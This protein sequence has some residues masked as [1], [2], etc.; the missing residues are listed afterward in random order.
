MGDESYSKGASDRRQTTT[1]T[2]L[3]E[4]DLD[5][6][7]FSKFTPSLRERE[8]T[9]AAATDPRGRSFGLRLVKMRGRGD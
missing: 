4:V 7:R 6:C 5:G 3:K 9:Y 8:E 2:L 1:P